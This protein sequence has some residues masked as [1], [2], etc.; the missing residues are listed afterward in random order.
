MKKPIVSTDEHSC[1]YHNYNQL[2]IL[3]NY[4]TLALDPAV[5]GTETTRTKIPADCLKEG[6]RMPSLGR[7]NF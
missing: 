4:S 2:E 6:S 5:A 3:F 1:N 7:Q